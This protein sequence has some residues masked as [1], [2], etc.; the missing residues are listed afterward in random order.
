[1]AW[2]AKLDARV[3]I[4]PRWVRVPYLALKWFLIA[5]GAWTAVFM[6]YTELHEGH[7]GIGTGIVI[8]AAMSLIGGILG[9]LT[10]HMPD[11]PAA[12]PPPHPTD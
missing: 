4:T 10:S 2:L 1:M 8:T 6:A 11:S 9:A 7:L 12:P 3:A 5:G